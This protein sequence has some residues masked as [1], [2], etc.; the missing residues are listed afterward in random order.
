MQKRGKTNTR[1]NDV[2]C[3]A[4]QR[5]KSERCQLAITLTCLYFHKVLSL[6]TVCHESKALIIWDS[7]IY[8]GKIERGAFLSVALLREPVVTYSTYV[9]K[10]NTVYSLN[11]TP[12]IVL[13]R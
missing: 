12:C 11:G 10:F 4:K 9:R 2:R 1:A 8:D 7:D 5:S 13:Y 6:D 3:D